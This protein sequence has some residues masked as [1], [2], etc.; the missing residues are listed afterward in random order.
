[1]LTNDENNGK[2]REKQAGYISNLA[3]IHADVSRKGERP[4]GR[5]R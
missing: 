4:P 3:E 5:C 2:G 1:M